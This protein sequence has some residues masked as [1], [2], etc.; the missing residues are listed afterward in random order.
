MAPKVTL[1]WPQGDG[2][3]VTSR[4]TPWRHHDGILTVCYPTYYCRCRRSIP[5]NSVMHMERLPRFI[6]DDDSFEEYKMKW[7]FVCFFNSVVPNWNNNSGYMLL[8]RE[9]YGTVWQSHVLQQTQR[10]STC[11][12]T[13]KETRASTRVQSS[14]TCKS[15]SSW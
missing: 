9:S 3:K 12:W 7:V 13:R 2:P 5:V 15:S 10:S 6:E 11:T 1:R 14:C 8:G 4:W